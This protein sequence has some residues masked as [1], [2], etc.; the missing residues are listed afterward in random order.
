MITFILI[1]SSIFAAFTLIWLFRRRVPKPIKVAILLT[2]LVVVAVVSLVFEVLCLVCLVAAKGQH[3]AA[4]HRPGSYH[5]GLHRLLQARGPAEVAAHSVVG[6]GRQ[7]SLSDPTQEGTMRIILV[8][9]VLAVCI[10]I[11]YR[12]QLR[13]DQPLITSQGPTI[14]KLERLSQLVTTRVQVADV[15]VAEGQGCRGSWLIKGDA[16]LSVNLARP[17]SSTSKRAPSRRRLSCL[18]HR[19]CKRGSIIPAPAPGAWN[20]WLGCPGTRTKMPS[21]MPFTAEAQKLVAHTAASPENISQAKL[22][23]ETVLKALYAEVG[24]SLAVKW[25]SPTGEGQKAATTGS[26]LL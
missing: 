10:A 2:S 24:W 4:G 26:A 19:C 20:A 11:V 22:T 25:D 15:L 1:A 18:S 21:A 8:L 17:K 12:R 6:G 16:L 3:R 23:A 5:G 7:F 9:V 14:E 13:I